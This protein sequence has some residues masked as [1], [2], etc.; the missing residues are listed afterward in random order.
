MARAW[1]KLPLATSYGSGRESRFTG[2]HGTNASRFAGGRKL[3][4]SRLLLSEEIMI[5]PSGV[6]SQVKSKHGVIGEVLEKNAHRLPIMELRR[7]G[8]RQR[9][10]RGGGCCGSCI[11]RHSMR[12]GV[13]RAVR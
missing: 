7:G 11:V 9:G 6:S 5:I 12:I 13:L 10:G 3:P 1:S 4:S 8:R 2:H